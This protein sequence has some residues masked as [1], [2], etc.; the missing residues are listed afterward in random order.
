[1]LTSGFRIDS[2]RAVAADAGGG[3]TQSPHALPGGETGPTEQD[4]E[5][6]LSTTSQETEGQRESQGVGGT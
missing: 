2:E 5:Q 1:M 6:V 3:T 4:Q